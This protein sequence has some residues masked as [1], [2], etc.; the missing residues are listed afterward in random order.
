MNT[1]N[2]GEVPKIIKKLC[3]MAAN[4][5]LFGINGKITK[6]ASFNLFIGNPE[7]SQL[8]NPCELTEFKLIELTWFS[9]QFEN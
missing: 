1:V 3:S 7:I 5:N 2:I 4:L 6:F 9:N 8:N